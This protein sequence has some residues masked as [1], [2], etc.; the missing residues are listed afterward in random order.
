M[1][2]EKERKSRTFSLFLTKFALRASEIF[3][4]NQ[5]FHFQNFPAFSQFGIE[6]IR[7]YDI[8]SIESGVHER[9]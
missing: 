8:I 1:S 9:K 6:D 7:K 3:G 4:V 5:T 2:P